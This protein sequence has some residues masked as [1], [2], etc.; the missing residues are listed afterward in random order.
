MSWINN[1]MTAILLTC[2]TGSVLSIVWF[3]FYLV[4]G[5]KINIRIM[6]GMLKCVMIAYLLPLLFL[7]L[8]WQAMY[9]DGA[10]GY[11]LIPTREIQLFSLII[12]LVWIIGVLIL[13]I[14][15][16]SRIVRLYKVCKQTTTVSTKELEVFDAMKRDLGIRRRICL[17]QGYS[18]GVPFITGM[19]HSTVYLPVNRFQQ[20]ELE[21]ILAH[22]LCHCKQGDTFW[23]PVFA[24]TCCAYWFNPLVWFVWKKMKRFAEA[25]CDSYCC[26]KKYNPKRYFEML[27]SMSEQV[28]NYISSFV[29]MWYEDENELKWRVLCIKRHI[30]MKEKRLETAIVVVIALFFGSISVHA[31]TKGSENLYA[32]IY[33][34]TIISEVEELQ[35]DNPDKEY[36]GNMDEFD[37]MVLNEE[38]NLEERTEK[39]RNINWVIDNNEIVKSYQFHKTEGSEIYISVVLEPNDTFVKLGIIQPDASI[40]YIYSKGNI[41]HTFT[42]IQNGYYEV[43]IANENSAEIVGVGVYTR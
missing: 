8:K 33:K 24:F 34:E 6:Y 1:L 23:K 29:P 31:A 17:R 15:N 19:I 9:M 32:A 7:L 42:I 22:E 35:L 2:V 21:M 25:S 40:R 28:E 10:E 20:E 39:T 43:F 5:R 4:V 27:S 12:F 37:G 3:L 11:L 30:P 14:Y 13:V 41:A 16:I 18:I 38:A 26:E 36:I